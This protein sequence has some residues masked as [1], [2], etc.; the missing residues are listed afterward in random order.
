MLRLRWTAP[1][2]LLLNSLLLAA[3]SSNTTYNATPQISGLFP[4]EIT[5]GSQ[6]FT[7]FV[8]GSNF[9]STSTVQWN[10]SNRP[11]TYNTAS[12]QLSVSITAADVQIP[13]IAQVTVTSPAPGG[14][15]SLALSFTINPVHDGSPTITN[16]SPTSAAL[17]G[18]AFN[19]AVTGTNFVSGDYVTWNGGLRTTTFTSAT[20][21]SAQILATDLTQQM[22]AGVA[23]H[24]SQLGIAS[25][26]VS[27]QVGSAPSSSAKFP[28]V[29]S[30]NAS[31][32]PADGASS[33]PAIS[34]DGRY[35]AFYSEAKN[36]TPGASGS[37]FVRDT[38]LGALNCTPHTSAVNI[39]AAGSAP[40][41]PA[42]S[43]DGV[44]VSADGRYVAFTSG[45]TNLVSTSASGVPNM[46]D[47]FVRDLC[48][49]DTAPA[50]CV[51]R[52]ELVSVDPK[53]ESVE[54][55]GATLSADG[56][57]V[58]FTSPGRAGGHGQVVFVRDTCSGAA[59][60][61]A[62]RPRTVVA[63]MDGEQEIAVG[64]GSQPAISSDGR[65]VAFAGT[66]VGPQSSEGKTVSQIF[67]RDT[68]LGVSAALECISS[69]A[70]ISVSSDAELGNADSHSP[71]ISSDGRFIVFQSG[72]SNLAGAPTGRQE[73]YLRDTC[74]GLTAVFNCMPSTS[75]ISSATGLPAAITGSY[76]PAISPSG[77]YVT[78]MVETEADDPLANAQGL[79]YIVLYD[80]C[81]G[82]TGAC[83]PQGSQLTGLRDTTAEVPLSAEIHTRVPLSNDGWFAAFFTNQAVP[84][85]NVSGLGDVLLTNTPV[86]PQRH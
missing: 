31:G 8:A 24:T 20:Q 45:A 16:I 69:T 3:C 70:R 77:R 48:L 60:D 82:T 15:T 76:S 54:G 46:R 35:V 28:Q 40:N 61:A 59:A 21:L 29:I 50:N 32:G 18:A 1:A 25:P 84:A 78:Y 73:I 39:G 85:T 67:V 11:A 6:A 26:S 27:F 56:R 17:N 62:C 13:G 68:C 10:G 34:A 22:V 52:T 80:T 30:V 38:C 65:Y 57:F 7:L 2:A 71:S 63:S 4:S 9:I 55:H 37:I 23:V 83:S 41:T 75:R 74:A 12:T 66:P 58:A 44:A 43:S 72:A 19:L 64:P 51:P 14:G 47:V 5:A 53:A 79:G 33:S 86:Q 36:L 49:G 42:S 81:F